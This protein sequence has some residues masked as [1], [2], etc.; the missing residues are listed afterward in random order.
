M[1]RTATLL[2]YCQDRQ[3]LVFAIAGFLLVH[4]GNILHADQHQDAERG[5]FFMR[6]QWSL[7]GFDLDKE[8]F[9]KAFAPLVAKH[10]FVWQLVMD[11]SP[12]K[13]AIF[14]SRYQHCLIDLL[15]RHQVGELACTLSLIISN[16]EDGARAGGFLSG[17][18]SSCSGERGE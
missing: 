18:V 12:P 5:L 17:A 3:G 10:S 2:L 14:V 9:A 1:E 13:V 4:G 15:Y 8:A 6:I 16:H 7:T 11:D